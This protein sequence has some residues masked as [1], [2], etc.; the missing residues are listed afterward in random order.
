MSY[1]QVPRSYSTMHPTLNP[2]LSLHPTLQSTLDNFFENGEVKFLVV[3]QD[4]LAVDS[5]EKSWLLKANPDNSHSVLSQ[6]S[7]EPD[8]LS[9]MKWKQPIAWPKSI[10][11][12]LWNS[13]DDA[14][15]HNL[16]GSYPLSK[17]VELLEST[18]YYH[19]SH[20]FGVR[21]LPQH[22]LSGLNRKA[23]RSISLVNEK[24][25]LL[26]TLKSTSDPVEKS[27][28]QNLLDDILAKL[29]LLRRGERN[30]KR[31]WKISNAR[32]AFSRNP[33]LAGKNILDPKC[34][35]KLEVARN[36]MD[37]HNHSTL[38]DPSRHIPLSDL[39]GLPSPP[40]PVSA[41]D[42]SKLKF[43]DFQAVLHSRRN[44]SSP[45]LNQIPYTVCK[46]C[47]HTASFL[48]NIFQACL[49]KF[50]IPVQWRIASE[51]Y[52]PKNNTP[53]PSNIKDFRP[54]A[55]LNVEGKLFFS[56]ISKR[57]ES[58]I[59]KKNF[60]N[61]SIQ[62]GCMEK[63]PGCWEHMSLVWSTL[64]NAKAQHSSLSAIWLDI[65]NAYPSVPHK[66]IFMALRRY[67]V[68]ESWI[69]LIQLYYDSLWSKSF[70]A[71]APSSWHQHCKGIFIGCT[72]S[73]ILFLAAI[74][75]IIECTTALDWVGMS[76][77]PSKSRSIVIDKGKVVQS[78]PFTNPLAIINL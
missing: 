75:V 34:S 62:K 37:S 19:A 70:S 42:S 13:L 47:P 39:P 66:L 21:S 56:L 41:F 55:L 5:T 65:A 12:K 60:I 7:T 9:T 24:N 61:T 25:N 14:V 10:D 27:N 50:F 26:R 32:R 1:Y 59:I 23:L 72:L 29:R 77:R 3:L 64:K 4:V 58:H 11:T 74:N 6:Q 43:K 44:A 38:N 28:M 78:S 36:E 73:I 76:F 18:I 16:L 30:K 54:I 45:R 46:N 48:F 15:F 8:H 33:Y 53:C 57:L 35:I 20:L 51:V 31:R 63:V 40:N 71:S 49:K 22:N 67:G 2:S 52:I 17:K 69:R 68:P